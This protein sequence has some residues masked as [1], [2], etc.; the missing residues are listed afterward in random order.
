[1][2]RIAVLADIHG[3]LPALEAVVA[4]LADQSVDEVLVGGDMVGRGPQGSAV[5]QRI[6]ELGWPSVKGNHEDYLLD[7][8]RGAVPADW[9]SMAS[10]EWSAAR[11][12]AAELAP[13]DVARI[14]ALPFSLTARSAPGLRLVHGST[15]SANEGLGPWSRD[16]ELARE[17]EQVEERL[18]VC[19]HTHRPMV[20][21][22]PGGTVVNVGSVGLPFNR[23]RRAQYAI[24]EGDGERFTI[25]P[26]AVPYDL[27]EIFAIYDSS[28]FLAAGGV[29]ARLLLLELESASP[30]LVPFLKWTETLGLAPELELLDEFL[31]FHNP[32]EP[33][34]AFY[35]K[36]DALAGRPEAR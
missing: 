15:R 22:L 17:L 35:R 21:R 19:A 20:R 8:R 24:F 14:D 12:M 31:A 11:W 23:D 2:S 16:D 30:L 25:E 9:L 32:D 34:S 26:R 36:L 6:A 3:N 13:E 18:L 7:F 5:V 27:E 29:T 1:M 33:L 10:R 28:G 4:D